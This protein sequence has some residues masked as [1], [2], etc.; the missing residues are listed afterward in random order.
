[1][2]TWLDQLDRTNLF[3]CRLQKV[4]FKKKKNETKSL[5]KNPKIENALH[6]R[7]FLITVKVRFLWKK[8]NL[9]QE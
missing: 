5:T 6:F 2:C 9:A 1:M 3:S 4:I 7:R 8:K